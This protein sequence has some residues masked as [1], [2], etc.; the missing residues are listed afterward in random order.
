MLKKKWLRLIAKG[1][2][3]ISEVVF[4]KIPA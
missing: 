1:E 3:G 2:A 4:S